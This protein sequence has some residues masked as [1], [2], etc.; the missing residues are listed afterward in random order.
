MNMR[1]PGS[2]LGYVTFNSRG[3]VHQMSVTLGNILV[4]QDQ[5]VVLPVHELI[6]TTPQLMFC[7]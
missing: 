3:I 7:E 5:N 2:L 4:E 1:V 6:S